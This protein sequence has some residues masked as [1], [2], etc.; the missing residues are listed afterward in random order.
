M[1]RRQIMNREAKCRQHGIKGFLYWWLES[2]HN[3]KRVYVDIG[4]LV[5]IA[6]SLFSTFIELFHSDKKIPSWLLQLDISLTF[7][8]LAEYIS[9]FFIATDF[10]EDVKKES[11]S[12]SYAIIHK[13]KWI[14]SPLSIIDLVALFPV[15]RHFRLFRTIR[16]LR[17]AKCLKL[18]RA[19]HLRKSL[20]NIMILVRSFKESYFLLFILVSGTLF[21]IIFNTT[22]LF[23]SESQINPGLSFFDYFTYILELIG[24]G[25][26][27]PVTLTGRLFAS[28]TMICN[29]VFISFFISIISTRMGEIMDN[30]KNGKLGAL[31]IS[32]HI[33][34]CGYSTSTEKVIEEILANKKLYSNRIVLVTEKKN[35][36]LG[37][38]I[39]YHGDYSNEDVLKKVNI[40]NCIMAVV[41]SEFQE[42][43]T[44]K[45]VDMR[46]VMTVYNIEQENSN[47]HTIAEIIN[48]DNSRIIRDRIKGDEIIFKETIDAHLI[49]NC[50]R[51]PF[52][53]PMVY[54]LLNLEG[55]ILKEARLSD[56]NFHNPVNFRELKEYQLDK[57]I[58]I[59]GY[60]S[61]NNHAVLAPKNEDMIELSD[62]LIYIE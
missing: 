27:T 16:I 2:E 9:R 34:L 44:I 43:D 52:I 26:G 53:S 47:V 12:F 39:Y 61:N 58:T 42:N 32:D 51:H 57:N 3:D 33:V 59:L 8:F 54:E 4:V 29:I 15:V 10:I 40:K 28:I 13:L 6:L 38:V 41:F 62:R 14:F 56:I 37:G 20:G 55:R 5:L 21:L 22:G 23:L 17:F 49:A 60:I 45:T 11:G 50:I 25:D 36:E 48:Q 31:N 30:I 7:V 1:A 46:T 18:L 35:P 24:L 19:F